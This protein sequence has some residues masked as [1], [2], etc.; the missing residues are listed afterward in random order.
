MYL[1]ISYIS[2]NQWLFRQSEALSK[3]LLDVRL[4]PNHTLYTWHDMP[5][6]DHVTML[7]GSRSSCHATT[8]SVMFALRCLHYLDKLRWWA[9]A[10]SRDCNITTDK[11]GS[12]KLKKSDRR[13]D[14][15]RR[16]TQATL[17]QVIVSGSYLGIP[18]AE[19]IHNPSG[20]FWV[21]PSHSLKEV[22]C[23]N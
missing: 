13:G 20:K 22:L 5:L 23:Q 9:F 10:S 4:L 2:F 16:E 12:K 3:V 19:R 11:T 18:R 15:S 17:S 8:T 1:V 14:R 7:L 6:L 21:F